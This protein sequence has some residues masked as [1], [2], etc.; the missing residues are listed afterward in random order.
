MSLIKLAILGA[1]SF[2]LYEI[3]WFWTQFRAG[4]PH[5]GRWAALLKT[6]FSGIF[7]YSIAR[8]VREDAEK[9]GVMCRYS[10]ALLTALLL[11]IGVA[12]RVLPGP[13]S[14]LLM[15]LG[16]V[17]LLPVQAAINR[18]NAA[19]SGAPPQ[20]WRWWEIAIATVFGLLWLLGLI[21]L[22]IPPPPH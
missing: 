20:G 8:E 4:A 6:I 10:P 17:P 15:L 1:T 12:V 19:T 14:L 11:M 16:P 3:W 7:F 9:H 2:W 18:V 21:G 5:E 22:L 13:A